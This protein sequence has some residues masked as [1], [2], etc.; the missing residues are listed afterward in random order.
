MID[1]PAPQDRQAVIARLH[2]ALW[3]LEHDDVAGWRSNVDALIQWRSQ[4]LVQGLAKLAREL[5]SALGNG[6]IAST[7]S[8]PEACARLEHVVHVSEDASHRTLDLIQ[9]C[10]TL[11]GTL[12]DAAVE[13]QAATIAAIRGRFS[14]MTAAQGYQDLT[15]QIIRRVVDLVRA[16]HAGLGEVADDHST[17]LHLNNHRGHGPSVAG[18]DPA[19]ATQ[20]DANE[21]L[22]SLG[23]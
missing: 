13:E 9:E 22:S 15:G 18:I 5:E 12:P 2:A 3:A 8:L 20:D 6:G 14:E 11:L 21:L 10:G 23:L 16:V 1:A 19:P 4:P 7:G 17:P